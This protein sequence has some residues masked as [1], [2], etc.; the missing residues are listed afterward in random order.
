MGFWQSIGRMAKGEPVFQAEQPTTPQQES[1]APSS[2]EPQPTPEIMITSLDCNENG[3]RLEVWATVENG[4]SVEVLI[5]DIHFLGQKMELQFELR[6]GGS[7][8]VRL[9]SGLTPTSNAQN[10]SI[11]Q[12]KNTVSGNYYQ[13]RYY[14]EFDYQSDGNYMP[15]EFHLQRP[16]RQL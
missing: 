12:Y 4:S 10:Y 16:I 1:A 2:A 14:I 15:E 5:D 6:P 7:R 8:S 11:L 9:F 3:N 13:A